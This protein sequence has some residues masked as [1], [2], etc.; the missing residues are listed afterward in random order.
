MHQP[1][2]IFDWKNESIYPDPK[3]KEWDRWA[4]EFLRRNHEYQDLFNRYVDQ[5][6]FV[7]GDDGFDTAASHEEL[8]RVASQ[9]GKE[10]VCRSVDI[11][12]ADSF[13]LCDFP[14]NP[15]QEFDQGLPPFFKEYAPATV[16]YLGK[17][18]MRQVVGMK[19]ISENE[20]VVCL[21]TGV[22]LEIQW[23]RM[24]QTLDALG[25]RFKDKQRS[26]SPSKLHQRLRVLD[27]KDQGIST[28]NIASFLIPH[29]PNDHAN[30]YLGTKE[31][32]ADLRAAE[33]LRDRGYLELLH[34]KNI[35][36]C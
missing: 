2:L 32:D 14:K 16:T 1:V 5:D 9:Q 7:L 27:A 33:D 10:F 12:I 18:K 29:K 17:D 6:L 25:I 26:R 20:V 35:P 22:P 11:A 13:G 21:N 4:W 34:F 23:K 28:S 31:I 24:Q 36:D 8:L 3:C 19:P 15:T 30:G